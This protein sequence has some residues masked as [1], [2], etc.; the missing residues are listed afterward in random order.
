MEYISNIIFIL[1][2]FIGI[3]FFL[4]NLFKIRRNILLGKPENRSDQPKQRFKLMLRIA[5][6]QGKMM[7]KPVA[8]F[9]HILIYVGFILINIDLVEIF[10]DGIFNTHR[11]IGQILSSYLYNYITASLDVLSYLV[12]IAVVVF[13]S[14][15][16][17]IKVPRLKSNEL[18]G[19]PKKDANIILIVEFLMMLA[20]I[21]ANS[22]EVVLQQKNAIHIVGYFPL[23]SWLISPCLSNLTIHQLTI[24]FS[25]C[26]WLH[27]I[28]ILIFMNY[29][30]Y[31]K[32]LH[33]L[34]AF[35]NTYYSNLKNKGEFNNL[36]SVTKEVKLMMDPN[37]NPFTEEGS[38]DQ[39]SKKFGANEVTDLSWIQLLNAY[40]CTE[41]GRCTS[42]C[43][44]NLTG[45]K[46]SPRKIMMDVRDRV[47]EVGRNID[48][49]GEF[50]EDGKQ[51]LGDYIT[52]EEIWACTTC[53]ACVESCPIQIDPL[54]IIIDL[55]RYLVME[56]SEVPQ[57]LNGMM[58]CI[59]NNNA[60]WP[61]NNTDR[62]NWS[63]E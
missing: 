16:N 27:Y 10:I 45:K 34:F 57:E 7:F 55:R 8:G 14:R 5:L 36:S 50:V 3:G 30:Y 25:S 6:G 29:L 9:F 41:C 20:V 13:F 54:S 12:L 53:N 59:E 40:T 46:L 18:S 32:H 11:Y 35:P 24:V 60:P 33:I 38:S 23:S 15:R 2:A 37:I 63:K 21:F 52:K 28:G 4:R 39:I 51:L 56:K 26:W 61:F 48:K 58:S 22:S 17:F 19:W 62:E 49:N 47:E 42:S 44:A 31:S 43:P 1:L